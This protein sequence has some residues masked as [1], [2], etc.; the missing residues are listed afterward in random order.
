MRNI[1]NAHRQVH[2]CF[3]HVYP[4]NY[5]IISTWGDTRDIVIKI[6]IHIYRDQS[7]SRC[8]TDS[9][10]VTI[11]GSYFPKPKHLS[12]HPPY[13]LVSMCSVWDNA[14]SIFIDANLRRT[15]A[16]SSDPNSRQL[17][18]R[19]IALMERHHIPLVL[20][21]R[22]HSDI[23]LRTNPYACLHG[24]PFTAATCSYP[25]FNQFVALRFQRTLDSTLANHSEYFVY[26][27]F[28]I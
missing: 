9:R 26:R 12:P 15:R 10:R 6:L 14:T 4:Y 16:T 5:R 11:R 28:H 17:C 3:V 18:V 21:F 19:R 13:S 24:N 25:V 22:N 2:R 20:V 27:I 7:P 1:V 8:R 23:I